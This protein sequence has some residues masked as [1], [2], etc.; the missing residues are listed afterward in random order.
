M[1][2]EYFE[3]LRKILEENN[4]DDVDGVIGYFQEVVA[5]KIEAG[6]S[7]ED[8]YASF[9]DVNDV[10]SSILGKTVTFQNEDIVT[11]LHSIEVDVKTSD[12]TFTV[13]DVKDVEVKIPDDPR[14]EII[15][16]G[17]ILKIKEKTSQSF[18]F[19]RHH[20]IRILFPKNVV[21]EKFHVKTMSG[22]IDI[23][24]KVEIQHIDLESLS[25]DIEIEKV[26]S[27]QCE[28]NSTSGDLHLYQVKI[29]EVN[30]E[31]VSGSIEI[32]ESD[33]EKC[34][35][36][37]VSGDIESE[38]LEAIEM[39]CTTVSGDIDVQLDMSQEDYFIEVHKLMKTTKIG[40]GPNLLKLSTT[41]GDV[42]YEFK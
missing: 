24:S 31:T 32:S 25:G 14:F 16:N 28:V 7:E 1:I 10:A 13:S 36:S 30:L 41:S 35:A 8:I 6:E 19:S 22:D 12:I 2:K 4:Y 23:A 42:E 37:S 29:Q 33:I 26:T 17:G 20:T 21:L 15:D 34:D 40:K 38:S 27:K 5:D 11:D 18:L 3:T 39:Q 9:E